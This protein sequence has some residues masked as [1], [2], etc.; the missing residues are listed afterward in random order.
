[1]RSGDGV[2]TVVVPA[3]R[4]VP[5]EPEFWIFVFG[6]LAVFTA[7]FFV[8]ATAQRA[9]PE[10]FDAGRATLDQ[11]I[12]VT[13]TVL[14]LTS[15]AAVA[16]AVGAVRR[17][18]AAV[19][20]RAYLA[21]IALGAGFLV[22]KAV[23]YGEHLR[24]GLARLDDTF[25]VDYFVFTG[26]HAVHVLLGLVCLAAV[27]ARLAA[28]ATGATGPGGP[29]LLVHEAV[30]TYWHMIDVVWIVLFTLIYLA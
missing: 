7:F 6:D 13:N 25:H 22:L 27:R 5:G 20:R 9:E 10:L 12:G 24:H 29:R 17:G 4:R 21:A 26:V 19:A 23:E 16:R 1:V 2:A 18:D 28:G 11:V 14:L 3:R 30:A 8:W 15:S